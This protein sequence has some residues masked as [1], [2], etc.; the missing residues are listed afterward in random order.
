[1]EPEPPQSKL[2]KM[3]ISTKLMKESNF[4]ELHQIM[5]A[6]AYNKMLID[7]KSVLGKLDDNL[8]LFLMIMTRFESVSVTNYINAISNAYDAQNKP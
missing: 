6:N 2:P 3:L 7:H 8:E 4:N 1:M 5:I